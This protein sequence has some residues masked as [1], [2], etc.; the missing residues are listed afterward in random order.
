MP[1]GL[2]FHTKS[3]KVEFTEFAEFAEFAVSV[4]FSHLP[5]CH[6]ATV[7]QAL[8]PVPVELQERQLK[9]ARQVGRCSTRFDTIRHMFVKL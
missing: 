3:E 6:G 7:P 4:S 1:L 5:E 8:D 9:A 2:D